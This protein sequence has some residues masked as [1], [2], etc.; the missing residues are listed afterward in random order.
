MELS[1]WF[2]FAVVSG[3]S[4]W[5]AGCQVKSN[6]VVVSPLA[7]HTLTVNTVNPS[8]GVTISVSQ[9][10]NA[11][12]QDGTATF[13]RTYAQGTAVLLAAPA[14]GGS[15]IFQSWTGCRTVSARTC[16]VVLDADVTVWANYTPV[17]YSLSVGSTNPASGTAISLA[18][19][20]NNGA[21]DGTTAFT[22]SYNAGSTVTL[23]A[24]TRVNY[25]VFAAWSGCTQTSGTTCT[26]T[27][28][29]NT[30]VTAGYT[31][32]ASASLTVKSA[33]PGGGVS[34]AIAPADLATIAGG[35]TGVTRYYAPG[36][37]VTITA[38]ATSG[39][40]TFS[41]WFGCDTV[42]ALTCTVE[43]STTSIVTAAYVTPALGTTYYVSGAG[44]DS[45][46]GTSVTAPF[47]T[48]Q[49]AANLTNP[50][51][52][53]YVMD[54]T[55]T[56]PANTVLNIARAGTAAAPIAYRGYPGQ[57]PVI[58]FDGFFGVNIKPTAAYVEV[59]GLTVY[60]NND[61]VTL[62]QAQAAQNDPANHP[63][64]NGNCIAG[65]GRSGTDT[66][67]QNHISVL[68]NVVGKCG[69]AG[70]AFNEADY[71]T[72]AGNTVFNSAWY[73]AYGNSGISINSSWNSDA[74]T[75]Y[76]IVINGNKLYN[77]QSFIPWKVQGKITDGEAIIIDTQRNSGYSGSGVTL[78]PYTGRTLVSN[79]V[80]YNN[81]SSA[82]EVFQ[83]DHV[84][85][86]NNSTFNND[87]SAAEP[88]RGEMNLNYADD[89]NVFNNIFYSA[90]GGSPVVETNAVTRCT[91]DY[92]LVYGG[93]NVIVTPEGTHETTADPRYSNISGGDLTKFDLTVA[94]SSSAVD[95][96]T[97]LLSAGVIAPTTDYAGKTRPQ[98]KGVDRGA[99]EQ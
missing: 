57:S 20:D 14:T 71:I 2:K 37:T 49:K 22:R 9:Q 21:K 50:G 15:N 92:N 27:L 85:V 39:G 58:S 32:P 74:N 45:N 97:G 28:N 73:N 1:R 93:S 98:G 7:T 35:S 46:A 17:V 75:S 95:T 13:T 3:A 44:S 64:L 84:D 61:N 31:T 19:A 30:P 51:D 4:L 23:T 56:N 43:V 53:V 94:A 8:T 91:V 18:P 89:V 79:N 68:N 48:I 36:T 47:R 33:N 40:N 59:S 80:I 81:G 90:T 65:D 38:P 76:K 87:L 66:Q 29:A 70:I 11:S 62:Q 16:T 60:G 99:F 63:E 41:G 52:I 88:G 10:D 25:S 82:V 12:A 72:I 26:V 42:S 96:G 6:Q 69:G 78:P 77:N 24:P 54:G 83:S 86:I 67:R 5:L 55:Y 34:V